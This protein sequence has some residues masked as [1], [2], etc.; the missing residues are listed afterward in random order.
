MT[1]TV[2]NPATGSPVAEVPVPSPEAVDGMVA[3][4][5]RAYRDWSRRPVADRREHLMRCH[6]ALGGHVE[7]MARLL[8]TEQGKPLAD[9]RAEVRLAVDW[10][11]HT[12]GLTLEPER[13]ADDRARISI[14]RVPHGVVAALAPSNYPVI[15]A[16]TKVAPALLAG[17][18]VVLK[19]SPLTPLSTVHMVEVLAKELPSGVLAV[20]PGGGEVGRAFVAHPGVALVSFTGSVE[21]GRAIG[22]HAASRFARVVLELGGNDAAVILPGADVAA[23]AADL[24]G[25]AMR[26][27][28]QFCAAVKRVYVPRARQAELVA[29]LAALAEST[30]VGDGLDAGTELGPVVSRAQRDRV[31]ALVTDARTAGAQVVTGGRPPDRPGHFY[32]PTIVTD[33]PDGTGLELTEQF[34]PALPVIGY[35]DVAE[36]VARANGTEYG[37]G[38]SVWGEEERARDVAGQLDCGTVWVNTHGDLRHDVPF[39]GVRSSGTGVEYGYWGLLEYTRI[40]V[41]NAR[42]DVIE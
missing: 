22:T 31:H 35:D 41:L 29:A 12:A 5:A 27:S 8:T 19:P 14:D 20:A 1:L 37:L 13:V 9:A 38:G 7:E 30:V 28:G 36:A 21:T 25:A 4:A 40:K 11:R 24:Y 17:N 26:N 39:G 23:I 33:L 15:L 16:V 18:T 2:E 6:A 42:R 34:G 3:D 10:F 32:P